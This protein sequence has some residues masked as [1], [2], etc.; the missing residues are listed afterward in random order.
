MNDLKH[1]P[2]K[3][4]SSYEIKDSLTEYEKISHFHAFEKNLFDEGPHLT[5]SEALP[6]G[7]SVRNLVS[8]AKKRFEW[9]Q[10][11]HTGKGARQMERKVISMMGEMFHNPDAVGFICYGGS[12]SDICALVAAKGRAFVKQFPDADH[13]DPFA[14][15]GLLPEFQKKSHSVVLPLHSHYSLFKGCALL[16]LEPIP[17]FPKEGTVFE[18][19][20]VDL[21]AAVREDTIAIVGTA[22]TWPY[23]AIDPIPEMGKIAQ[24]HDLYLHVDACFGGFILP[25]LERSGYHKDLPEWDFR[26][27]GVS[28]ISADLHKNG[29]VPAPASSMYFRDKETIEYARMI[30]PPYGTLTG[31]RSTGPMA[32]SWTMLNALGVDGYIK[33]SEHSMR[34]REEL[35]EGVLKISG[36]KVVEGGLINLTG[37]YSEEIDLR[38]VSKALIDQEWMHVVEQSPEPI[39][40]V[41]CTMPQN[42]GQIKEFLRALAESVEKDAVPMGEFAG[43]ENFDLYGNLDLS[44]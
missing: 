32:A 11:W 34:L 40:L 41:I 30:S 21:E 18:M 10:I 28:S 38:P 17:V 31:T 22:G 15:F 35:I 37:I 4:L 1:W 44:I 24:K 27:P 20:P 16:G 43:S 7:D 33:V 9:G 39:T 2:K 26:V 13:S 23:G 5:S 8:D 25:F 19:D 29:M 12:E 14:M 42:D 36:L 3:R 6:W